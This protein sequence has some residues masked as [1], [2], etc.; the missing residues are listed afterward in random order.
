MV[1]IGHSMGGLVARDF[2]SRWRHPIGPV[3]G[4]PGIGGPSVAGVILVGTPNAGSEW[5]RLRVWLEVRDHFASPAQRPRLF[6]WQTLGLTLAVK[7]PERQGE[8]IEGGA[9]LVVDR[10]QQAPQQLLAVAKKRG[11]MA[12]KGRMYSVVI[13]Q[14][15]PGPLILRGGGF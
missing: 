13:D 2:V 12:Q 10:I 4:A 9:A 11:K 5:A 14:G 7:V 1:L 15:P 6:H 3:Q 8:P